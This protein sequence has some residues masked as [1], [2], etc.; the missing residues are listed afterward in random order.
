MYVP[1][2]AKRAKITKKAIFNTLSNLNFPK[3]KCIWNFLN[4][5]KNLLSK[6]SKVNPS[7]K[8]NAAN[9]I[10]HVNNGT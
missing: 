6:L 8:N 10:S 1:K 3:L 2:Q 7:K 5:G 4:I 9:T